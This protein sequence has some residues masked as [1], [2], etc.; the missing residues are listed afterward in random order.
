MAISA[1]KNNTDEKNNDIWLACSAN[2]TL[3][4][5]EGNQIA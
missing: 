5:A 3:V 1:Q 4:V 2:L